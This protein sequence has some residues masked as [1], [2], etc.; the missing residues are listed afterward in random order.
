M[1]IISFVGTRP[2]FIKAA[3][4]DREV[5]RRGL[6]HVIY[7]TGQHYDYEMA[8]SFFEI[9]KMPVTQLNQPQAQSGYVRVME[10]EQEIL[11]VLVPEKE[12]SIFVY[13]DC[14]SSLSAAMAC[15]RLGLPFAHIES[16]VRTRVHIAE[17][18]NR[19]LTD[20]L[21]KINIAFDELSLKNLQ[22]EHLQNGVLTDDPMKEILIRQWES[23]SLPKGCE[24]VDK[25][26]LVTLHRDHNVD[27][28][29]RLSEIVKGLGRTCDE[30]WT[31]VWPVHPRTR[32]NIDTFGFSLDSRICCLDSVP[33]PELLG[34]LGNSQCVITDSGGV[35]REAHW[36]GLPV[37][38]V[39]Q[40]RAWGVGRKIEPEELPT[41]LEAGEAKCPSECQAGR[42]ILDAIFD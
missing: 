12:A 42:Q 3:V 5:R 34:L 26:I 4:I 6:E 28:P 20:H 37:L 8:G 23:R 31:P 30:G 7:S 2:Q 16:G 35:Q 13:G 36:L 24:H 14:D 17:E 29:Q 38:I 9:F 18:Y 27:D 32:K 11:K 22:E 39:A 25:Q 10:M 40:Y 21:A 41:A 1:K 15:R 19:F 33:Y